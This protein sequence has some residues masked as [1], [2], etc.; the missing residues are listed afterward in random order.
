LPYLD[1]IVSHLILFL[2]TIGR[3]TIIIIIILVIS[4][5]YKNIVRGVIKSIKVIVES[6]LIV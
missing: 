6:I 3:R 5:W 2:V 4:E 1:S